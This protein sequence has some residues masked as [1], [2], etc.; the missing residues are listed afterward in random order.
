MR[1]VLVTTF[2]LSSISRTYN[3]GSGT[4]EVIALR[5]L[6]LSLE[7]GQI[8]ALVGPSGCG[9]T[10]LLNVLAGLDR[11]DSGT[12]LANGQPFV[13]EQVRFGYLFQT[14][15]L[16]PWRTVLGN[17]VLGCEILG[18]QRRSR[19]GRARELLERYGL[20]EFLNH[21]P[22]TLSAGMQQRVAL[23]RLV[24][25]GADVLLLDEP[26]RGLDYWIRR[27]L[28]RNIAAIVEEKAITTVLVTHDIEEAVTLGDRIYVLS[29]RPAHV[30]AQYDV[31][32]QRRQ[33]LDANPGT[34]MEMTSIFQSVWNDLRDTY[35]TAEAS[36][37]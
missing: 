3:S 2:H 20:G 22:A 4:N 15:S 23:I 5:D 8:T 26:F 36:V 25:Y 32:V 30:G 28:Q 29:R 33:R 21:Y 14:P 9:K 12:I 19:E 11:Q 16:V 24:L 35:A 10:T 18:E 34:V 1:K 13:P 6:S 27:E 37:Q 31:T 7:R 17:A